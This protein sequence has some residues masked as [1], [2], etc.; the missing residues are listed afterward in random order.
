MGFQAGVGAANLTTVMTE[1]KT[2]TTKSYDTIKLGIDAHAK[3]YYVARQ[4]DGTTPQP[5]QKM[6]F[7]A[8]LRFV[9]KQRDLAGEVHTCYE[10]GAFGYYLHRKLEALGVSNLVVQAQDWDERG[11]GVKTDRIDALALRLLGN[12]F[13]DPGVPGRLSVGD[14]GGALYSFPSLRR[15]NC[16]C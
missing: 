15:K 6:T 9:A 1:D 3:W 12:R 8:L 4:L 10:A 5:V 16:H 11:K 7:E 13:S 14:G 2:K